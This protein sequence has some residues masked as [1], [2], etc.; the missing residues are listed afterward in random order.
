M[1]D[2]GISRLQVPAW[3]LPGPCLV[4][5]GSFSQTEPTSSIREICELQDAPLGTFVVHT[6]SHDVTLV[7]R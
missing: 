4:R 1:D 5:P 2:P 7:S 6:T 3:S